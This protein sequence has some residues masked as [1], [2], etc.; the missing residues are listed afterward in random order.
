MS[1]FLNKTTY[2]EIKNSRWVKTRLSPK[3]LSWH[4]I[5]LYDDDLIHIAMG[6]YPRKKEPSY[7]TLGMVKLS[8][9]VTEELNKLSKL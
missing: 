8:D 5:K 9:K 7:A 6:I 4:M 1:V 3:M 2:Y